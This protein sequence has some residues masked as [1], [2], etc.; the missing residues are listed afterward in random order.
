MDKAYKKPTIIATEIESA[1]I[2]TGSDTKNVTAG[3]NQ[4]GNPGFTTFDTKDR[5]DGVDGGMGSLW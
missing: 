5:N 3:Q 1:Q 2:M 4:Y